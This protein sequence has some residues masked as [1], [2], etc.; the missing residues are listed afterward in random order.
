MTKP[1]VMEMDSNKNA[2]I[3]TGGTSLWSV[4]LITARYALA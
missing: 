4:G 3:I 2:D 1:I